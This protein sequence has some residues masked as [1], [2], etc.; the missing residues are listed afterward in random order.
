MSLEIREVSNGYILRHVRTL[1]SSYGT[2]TVDTETIF[3]DIEPL[4]E[5]IRKVVEDNTKRCKVEM[6]K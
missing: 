6:V 1:A 4:L 2:R 3:D 5:H